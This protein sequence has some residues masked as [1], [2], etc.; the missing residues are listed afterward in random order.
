VEGQP[1]DVKMKVQILSPVISPLQ[2]Q[3]LCFAT[4]VSQRGSHDGCIYVRQ[5]RDL[6]GLLLLGNI[7]SSSE[8]AA[9]PGTSHEVSLYGCLNL[10][11]TH[12]VSWLRFP[13]GLLHLFDI[14]YFA[15]H[16][17]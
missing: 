3:L 7:H 13:C 15:I 17:I 12:R 4:A 2:Y 8:T 10:G 9:A 11:T 6:G 5:V 16:P 14:C 1:I